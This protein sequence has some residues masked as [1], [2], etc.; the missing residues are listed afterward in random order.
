MVTETKAPIVHP[1]LRPKGQPSS[2]SAKQRRTTVRMA[3]MV[4][5]FASKEQGKTI[6]TQVPIEPSFNNH[7][8]YDSTMP[9]MHY[10]QKGFVFPHDWDPETYD[11]LYCAVKD[12]WDKAVGQSERCA[13]HEQ[14]WKDGYIRYA[15]SA[16]APA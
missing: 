1:A 12:C 8:S 9:L 3:K 15:T 16:K 4:N 10:I 7:G 14:M 13:E 5:P 2:G 6:V 11:F